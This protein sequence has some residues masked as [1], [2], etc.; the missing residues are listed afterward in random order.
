[1]HCHACAHTKT[2]VVD[3]IHAFMHHS[4]VYVNTYTN[5][6][7]YVPHIYT[8]TYTHGPIHVVDDIYMCVNTYTGLFCR[9]SSVL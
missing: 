9:I 7:T 2:H 6:Y 5:T 8:K 1:M 4:C 3:D